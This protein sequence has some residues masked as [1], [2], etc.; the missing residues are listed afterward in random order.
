MSEKL[1]AKVFSFVGHLANF[2]VINLLCIACC[3]PV[4]TAGPSICAMYYCML[5]VVRNQEM[6]P[7]KDFSHS[8]KDNLKQGC[9]LQLIVLAVSIVTAFLLKYAISIFAN[10]SFYQVIACIIFIIAFAVLLDFT[11][12]YPAQAQFA[13][14]LNITFKNAFLFAI[15]NLPYVLIML[16]LNIL[17]ILLFL[18]WTELFIVLIPFYLFLG[19]AGTCYA[20]CRF[21]KKIFKPYVP[22]ESKTEEI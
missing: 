6:K 8:F 18:G 15:S 7:V 20:N 13:N 21:L 1:S 4:V 9:I 3:I 2:I 10:G 14:P 16:L 12:L 22:E 17:P 5:K 11:M 19:F